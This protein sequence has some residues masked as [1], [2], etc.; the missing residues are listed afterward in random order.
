MQRFMNANLSNME[1]KKFIFQVMELMMQDC[2][3]G[4]DDK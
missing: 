1:Y 4:F 2:L 3:I